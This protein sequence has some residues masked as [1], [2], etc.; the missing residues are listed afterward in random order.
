MN[1]DE[2]PTLADSYRRIADLL[3]NHPQ[4]SDWYTHP[5]A[6]GNHVTG[7]E[8]AWLDQFAELFNVPIEHDQTP[9]SQNGNFYSVVETCIEGIAVRLQC[10]SEDYEKATGKTIERPQTGLPAEQ[11]AEL[12]HW[13][14]NP[15]PRDLGATS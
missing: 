14:E 8:T 15:L 13:A 11:I 9:N 6:L 4:I 2:K 3:D 7:E 12:K 10:L 1:A 5:R